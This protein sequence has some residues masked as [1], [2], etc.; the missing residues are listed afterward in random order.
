MSYHHHMSICFSVRVLS[1]SY[2]AV[3]DTVAYQS[4][5]YVSSSSINYHLLL[6]IVS[7][8]HS[9]V[10]QLCLTERRDMLHRNGS[11]ELRGKC[12]THTE[13]RWAWM[14][15]STTTATTT[16]TTTTMDVWMSM[17]VMSSG[18]CGRI[19]AGGGGGGGDGNHHHYHQQQKAPTGSLS[20]VPIPI[21]K[22]A[23]V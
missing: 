23:D 16:T 15:P 12:H 21:G 6:R 11:T 2:F 17:D 14:G 3:S 7:S 8:L 20:L 9:L 13:F 1:I 18:H 10:S 5:S 22:V 19:P 4:V